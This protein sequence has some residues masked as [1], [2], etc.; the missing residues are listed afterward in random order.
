[1][2]VPGVWGGYGPSA[3]SR[4]R[5][6]GGPDGQSAAG[7]ATSGRV[8]GLYPSTNA[9]G[10]NSWFYTREMQTRIEV[11]AWTGARASLLALSLG[12]MGSV[13]RLALASDAD[14]ASDPAHGHEQAEGQKLVCSEDPPASRGFA[15]SKDQADSQDPAGLQVQAGSNVVPNSN[16]QA[17]SSQ[18]WNQFRGAQGRGIA[19]DE[20]TYPDTLDPATNLLWKCDLPEGN[21]S[22][23][24]WEDRIFLTGYEDYKLFTICIDRGNGRVLWSK[25][26][27]CPKLERAHRINTP[28]SPTPCTDGE[29]VYVYFGAFGLISYDLVGKEIWRR[30]LEMPENTFGTAASPILAKGQLIFVN[31]SNKGSYLE[32]IDPRNGETKW[33]TERQAHLSGWSTPSLWRRDGVD[34]LLVYGNWWMS[35]YDLKDGSMRWSVPGLADEPIVMPAVGSGYVFVSSYNMGANDEVIGLPSFPTLLEQLD[36]DGNGELDRTE[37]AQNQSVLSRFDANGEGDHPLRI[38]FKFLDVNDDGKLNEKEYSKLAQWLGDFKHA[39]GVVA[40]LP[41]DGSGKAQLAWQSPRGVPECPSPL[42]HEG[43]LYLLKNGGIATCLDAQSGERL[44]SGRLG[45]Q[46]PYYASPVC[47][48]GK[49]YCA[50]AEG[51]VTVIEAGAQL[52]VL[53]SSDLA[54]RIM[55]TPALSG[56]VLYLRAEEH[57]FAFGTRE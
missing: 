5:H 29:R 13:G 11:R 8:A 56:G 1:M 53:S 46:G 34:E 25:S 15:G 18:Q 16:D 41:D 23:C 6:G 52:K 50:S 39:N 26:L 45:A 31:D 12:T 51:E 3:L 7:S 22:P 42:Y 55:A 20:L 19:L 2:N 36:A 14:L 21:S 33:R 30:E 43:R 27:P 47:A 4:T 28:A 35:A 24:L 10:A 38:F 54:E 49:I 57:I 9:A 40:I 44:F 32:S 37:A 17:P 48:D